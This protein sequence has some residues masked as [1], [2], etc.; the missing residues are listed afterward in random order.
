MLRV[1]EEVR[2][3]GPHEPVPGRPPFPSHRHDPHVAQRG[4]VR[5][6]GR[7][8]QP[9]LAREVDDAPLGAREQVHDRQAARLGERVQEARDRLVV[10]RAV[11]PGSLAALVVTRR[12]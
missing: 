8:G 5:R 4:E 3:L 6:D 1:G 10:V 9:E 12:S 7:L 2:D 11:V